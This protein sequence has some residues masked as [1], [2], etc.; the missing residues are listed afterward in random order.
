MSGW[1]RLMQNQ[2]LFV[3]FSLNQALKARIARLADGLD[4][5]IKHF[6]IFI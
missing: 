1:V 3:Y 4:F 5:E 6:E 2:L